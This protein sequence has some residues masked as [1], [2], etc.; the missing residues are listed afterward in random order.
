MKNGTKTGIFKS[1]DGGTYS[2]MLF[3]KNDVRGKH[4]LFSRSIKES[5]YQFLYT[6]HVGERTTILAPFSAT[7]WLAL[8]GS[9]LLFFA[10]SIITRAKEKPLRNG[11]LGLVSTMGSKLWDFIDAGNFEASNAPRLSSRISFIFQAVLSL[12]PSLS[13]PEVPYIL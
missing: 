12:V 7:V 13:L 4:F 3:L 1:I 11:R 9:F 6:K 2:T 5:Y 10:I 8:T